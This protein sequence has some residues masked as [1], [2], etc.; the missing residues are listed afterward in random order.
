MLENSQPNPNIALDI[1]SNVPEAMLPPA[2]Q[3]DNSNRPH[4]EFLQSQ[5]L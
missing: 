1:G 5:Y 4:L 2:I 3:V